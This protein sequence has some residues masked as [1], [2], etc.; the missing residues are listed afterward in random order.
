MS[1]Q[2]LPDAERHDCGYSVALTLLPGL[3]NPIAGL[4]EITVENGRIVLDSIDATPA[5]AYD[6]YRHT[7]LYSSA[8]RDFLD[9][10]PARLPEIDGTDEI[11]DHGPRSIS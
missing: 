8:L 6:V 2:T 5:N 10:R 4:V 1:V 11:T 7:T 9:Q 3:T